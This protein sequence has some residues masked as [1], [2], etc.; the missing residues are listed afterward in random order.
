MKPSLEIVPK[1]EGFDLRERRM[2]K[3]EDGSLWTVQDALHAACRDMEGKNVT[4]VIIAWREDF[5]DS[6]FIVKW[7][8]SAPLGGLPGMMINLLGRIMGWR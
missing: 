5:D 3:N 7:R 2:L 6:S 8:H 1:P 4:G